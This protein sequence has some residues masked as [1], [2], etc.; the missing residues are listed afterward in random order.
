[1]S[2]IY[3]STAA[4]SASSRIENMVLTA[5][6]GL[7]GRAIFGQ[8]ASAVDLVI[9]IERMRDGV[10]R[11]TEVCELA[12]I[13]NDAITLRELFQY[14]FIDEGHDGKLVGVFEATGV[15]PRFLKRLGYY[16]LDKEFL[17]LLAP[18]PGPSA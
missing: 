10:R 3:A 18:P 8:I 9:Q 13:E 6:V 16:G 11:I 5:N 2:T 14:R 12:P 4:E 17:A 1:M 7:P 15:R